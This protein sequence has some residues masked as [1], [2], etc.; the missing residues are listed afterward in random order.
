MTTPER[1][2]A[3][4]EKRQEIRRY[5]SGEYG[6]S[7]H[8]L[9][10]PAK[11][12][13]LQAEK[14]DL[15]RMRADLVKDLDAHTADMKE[16]LRD[17]LTEEQAGRGPVPEPVR[18]GW[19][20]MSRLDWVDFLVR[21]S[22]TVVG[23]LLLLGLFTRPAAVAGAALILSFYL[24]VPPLPG[25][26]ENLRLEGYPYVNKNLIEVLTL[27]L[28]ATTSVGRWAGLDALLHSLRRPK[29]ETEVAGSAALN[30]PAR[31]DSGGRFR[32]RAAAP[33]DRDRTP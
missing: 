17:V 27:L 14:A 22:L 6:W 25:I 15:A 32:D 18:V 2:R 11:T 29:R 33:A 16:A 30:G 9:F 19:S 4:E 28:L 5:Q 3:Y 20:E 13:D 8:T 7:L 24:A 10:G 21:W 12:R 23:A 26:P 31:T 1:V